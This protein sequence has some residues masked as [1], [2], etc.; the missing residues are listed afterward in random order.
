MSK[1]RNESA[2]L[3]EIQKLTE[4]KVKDHQ[5]LVS[6]L[7]EVRI[8][9]SPL[10]FNWLLYFYF[11]YFIYAKKTIALEKDDSK[12]TIALKRR[13]QKDDSSIDS[14]QFSSHVPVFGLVFEF[15]VCF[16]WCRFLLSIGGINCIFTLFSTLG[17]MNLDHDFF[18][19]SK[20]S[21]DQK[22]GLHRKLKFFSRNHVKTK[23]KGSNIIQR[24][25]ADQSQIFGGYAVKLLGGISPRVSAPQFVQNHPEETVKLQLSILSKDT[26]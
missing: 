15:G 13:Y 2:P 24:S 5:A 6:W 26:T 11:L 22:K 16:Q 21:E 20:L 10:L 25:D 4:E 1:A 3:A 9:I 14:N 8:I 19:V 12:K 23:K 7:Y 17:G 18:Q